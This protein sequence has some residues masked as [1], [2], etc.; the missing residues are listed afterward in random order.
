V[1]TSST[2]A[3]AILSGTYGNQQAAAQREL[4]HAAVQHITDQLQRLNL[5]DAG[6]VSAVSDLLWAYHPVRSAAHLNVPGAAL[7]LEL[8]ATRVV[9]ALIAHTDPAGL[10]SLLTPSAAFLQ[11]G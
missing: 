3:T 2:D 1:S 7:H 6:A 9:T 11:Q 8:T 4:L 5:S 10:R